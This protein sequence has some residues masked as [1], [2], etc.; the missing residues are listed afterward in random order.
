MFNDFHYFARTNR[1][2]RA[3]HMKWAGRADERGAMRLRPALSNGRE[4]PTPRRAR[5]S[6]R[7]HP[8][9]G[10]AP[11]VAASGGVRLP[12][13]AF[14]NSHPT[15]DEPG[16]DEGLREGAQQ[17]SPQARGPPPPVPLQGCGARGLNGQLGGLDPY[18]AL[19]SPTRQGGLEG[20]PGDLWPPPHRGP[21]Y[22]I[23]DSHVLL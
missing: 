3:A 9:R 15:S 13:P 20:G 18:G 6:G 8:R 1:C 10:P 5:P 7:A 17:P 22:W 16:L 19:P 11:P 12:A 2:G 23:H 14:A 4:P 21:I